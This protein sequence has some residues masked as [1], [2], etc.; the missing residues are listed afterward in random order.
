VRSRGL[1]QCNACRRQTS[2]I[3][4]TIFASTHLPG[5]IRNLV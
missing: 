2:P 3:A 5:P 4:G 1:F